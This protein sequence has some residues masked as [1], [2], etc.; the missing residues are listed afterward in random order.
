MYKELF[1][2]SLGGSINFNATN[3]SQASAGASDT[4]YLD[5]NIN[6]DFNVNLPLGFLIGSDI[7]CTMNRGRQ[8]GY[9][10]TSTMW[11]AN[12]SKYVFPKKQG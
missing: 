11:N 10:L 12:V 3:Y 7:T 2:I 1:D 5:Y 8:P 6:T 9:N 4:R